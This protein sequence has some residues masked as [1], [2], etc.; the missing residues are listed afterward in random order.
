MLRVGG[1]TC[2]GCVGRV[3]DALAAVDGVVSAEVTLE[4]PAATVVGAAPTAAL[5][6]AVEAV[7]KSAE[8]LPGS[9]AES[10]RMLPEAHC[11]LSADRGSTEQD[12]PSSAPSTPR[13][14]IEDSWLMAGS[15]SPNG[16][17]EK[18]LK[19]RGD[20]EYLTVI[21]SVAGMTCSSCVS[22]VES[23]LRGVDGVISAKVNLLAGRAS[24]LVR[25]ACGDAAERLRG[26]VDGGGYAC[27]IV[28][29]GAR[30]SADGPT[31][32]RVRCVNDVKAEKLVSLCS[33]EHCGEADHGDLVGGVVAARILSSDDGATV[34]IELREGKSVAGLLRILEEGGIGRVDLLEGDEDAYDGTEELCLDEAQVYRRKLVTAVSFAAPLIFLHMFGH[35]FGLSMES[36]KWIL[37]MLATPVQFYCGG[38]FYRA[39]WHALRKGRA[40]M[41][42]LISL[43]TSIAY[44]TSVVVVLFGSFAGN[45]HGRGIGRTPMFNVSS[46]IITYVLFGKW[47][48]SMAKKRAAAGIVGLAALAPKDAVFVD[49]DADGIAR[50]TRVPIGLLRIGD[51]VRVSPGEQVP[52]DSVVEAGVSAIDE[53]MVTGESVPVMKSKGDFCYGGTRNGG[54]G[55]REATKDR[56]GAA[57]LVRVAA[58]EDDSTLAQIVK[59]VDEAQTKRAP[60][61]HFADRISAYFVPSVVTL[62][63]LTFIVWFWAALAGRIPSEWFESEGAFSFA[64]LFAL[65]TMVIACPCALG[66]ATPTAVMVASEVSTRLGILFKGGGSAM[67]ATTN[68]RTVLFDK[69]GTLTM[70][71]PSVASV[72]VGTQAHT[73]SVDRAAALV[74]DLVLIVEA[75]SRHPLADAIVN[76]IVAT[77][78]R[79]AG[80]GRN[81]V[82]VSDSSFV[83]TKHAE[84][85]GHGMEATF[86]DRARG[87]VSHTLRIGSRPWA[88]NGLDRKLFTSEELATLDELEVDSGFTV[89]VAVVDNTYAVVYALEDEVRPEAAGVIAHLQNS[90]GM[91]CGMVTG[92]SDEAAQCIARKVGIDP[93]QIISRALPI[94]KCE[95]VKQRPTGTVCFVGDGINDGAALSSAAV[96]IAIGSGQQIATEAANV[97]LVRSDLCGVVHALDLGQ[98]SF[99]RVYLN[100]MLATVYNLC[101]IPIAAGV[102]YPWK[103]IRIPPSMASAAMALS[104]TAVV[105]SSIALRRY[106]APNLGKTFDNSWAEEGAIVAPNDLQVKRRQDAGPAYV[107]VDPDSNESLE[108]IPT[109]RTADFRASAKT[110]VAGPANGELVDLV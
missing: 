11:R 95:I 98:T 16:S 24:V 68:I 105:L 51:L 110:A 106:V 103:Q 57:L 92:D 100:F 26:K 53:S 102:L 8:L 18:L 40:T 70:G 47:L 36:L 12:P 1:M 41:D 93:S 29:D 109:S 13:T 90:L 48:E 94:D 56:G 67:E 78:E 85:P 30:A 107:L 32:I 58:A 62:S 27:R 96:G 71:A 59:V 84:V 88:L 6:A 35:R 38:G 82:V 49:G 19:A 87:N 74:D 97:V 76:H 25:D 86:L 99:R 89:V 44:F 14:G 31:T 45:S 91:T 77:R 81:V 55:F 61:E 3:R 64:L 33:L 63:L 73:G 42:V 101:G 4:P 54:G 22:I 43:S 7:H 69:T 60:V 46:M 17:R 50:R 39:S 66:L 104:S 37:W 79:N 65:E 34:R 15:D 52:L 75:E 2:G 10:R 21:L 5:I 9:V 20:G 28:D 23:L 80:T 108:S 83:M 72:V